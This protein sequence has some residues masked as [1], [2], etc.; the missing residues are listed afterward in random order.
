LSGAVL[1]AEVNGSKTTLESQGLVINNF[2]FPFSDT[3]S[4]VDAYVSQ[5]YE[6]GRTYVG[7]L[8]PMQYP[9]PYYDIYGYLGETGDDA[10]VLDHLKAG[11]DYALD[12]NRWVVFVF[13]NVKPDTSNIEYE[14]S[15]ALFEQF[16]QYITEKQV[17]TFTVNQI[18][19]FGSVQYD[20]MTSAN[21][22]TVNPSSGSY[23]QG[24]IVPISA[25]SPPNT[26]S[27]RYVF[28]HW[29]GAGRGSYTG[30]NGTVSIIMTDNIDQTAYWK[31]QYNLTV[32]S[33]QAATP[34]AGTHWVDAG[35]L[36]NAY[37]STPVSGPTGV[38]Y[39]CTGY[40]G[41]GSVSPA[42]GETSA[43]SFTMNA[44]STIRWNWKTQYQLTTSTAYGSVAGANWYDANTF[45][46]VSVPSTTVAGTTGTQYVFTN[47]TGDASGTNPLTTINMTAPKTATAN[48]KTQ[49]YLTISTPYSS[50]VGAGWFDSG[51]STNASIA[52]T[53]VAG[54]TG[55]QYVFTNWSGGASG[56]NSTSEG[57][58]MNAPKTATANWKT[59]YQVAFSVSPTAAGSTTP[60]GTTWLDAGQ[61]A[62]SFSANSGYS[63][64][65]WSVNTGS[66][67]IANSGSSST[68]ATVNG[69]GTIFVL[70][71]GSGTPSPTS[72]PSPTAKPTAKPSPTA[73]PTPTPNATAVPTATPTLR[74]SPTPA[75]T[76]SNAAVLYGS[77]VAIAL[78]AGILGF[79]AI[80]KWRK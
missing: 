26:T 23:A 1:S 67:S 62:I 37:V 18:Q 31:I 71:S 44:A 21:Y 12:Y 61:T 17:P 60:S 52:A 65:S 45:A 57:I 14:I 15:T 49:Y 77:V 6:S 2:A 63:F 56:T 75:D 59:Q 30:P 3:N 38:R 47:W 33:T 36:V 29:T 72:T 69:P 32:T 74:P 20:L 51:V 39:Q 70:T 7:S 78:V 73:T 43:V 5:N 68:T 53:T 35:T 50:G 22:G 24:S 58:V 27:I 41:T 34:T 28:D 42:N 10:T 4:T 46:T 80:R 48:W 64:T 25:T 76:G 40:N 11:V 66:I 79:F 55:T 54:D 13:H 8:N 16:L 9:W 19:N